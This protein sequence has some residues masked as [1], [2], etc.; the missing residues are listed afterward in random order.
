MKKTNNSE[1]SSVWNVL[2]D[3]LLNGNI[4]AVA[5][6]FGLKWYWFSPICA[7]TVRKKKKSVKLEYLGIVSDFF[8]IDPSL[9]GDK[10]WEIASEFL[11][12]FNGLEDVRNIW[13][14]GIPNAYWNKC[15]RRRVVTISSLCF[16]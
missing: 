13:D 6:F 4:S 3:S 11:G 8:V 9:T 5:L 7:K 15:L 14:S 1:F 2:S 16:I 10:L 12:K